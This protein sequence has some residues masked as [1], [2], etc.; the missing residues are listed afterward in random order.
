MCEAGEAGVRPPATSI[1][2]FTTVCARGL[3]PLCARGLIPLPLALVLLAQ[4]APSSVPGAAGV[5]F[6]QVAGGTPKL[7]LKARLKAASDS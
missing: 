7:R 5:F 6:R 3:T 4:L 1:V 2:Q